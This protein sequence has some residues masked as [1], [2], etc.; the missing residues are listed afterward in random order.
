MQNA[1]GSLSFRCHYITVETS[2]Q[3]KPCTGI[4]LAPDCKRNECRIKL[5]R[6]PIVDGWYSLVQLHDGIKL[7]SDRLNYADNAIV[8]G[9]T[10][11]AGCDYQ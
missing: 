3:Q 7:S 10:P 2:N 8:C 4:S 11:A 9:A 1:C 6:M 5:E